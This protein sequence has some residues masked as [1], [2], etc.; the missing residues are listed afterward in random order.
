MSK[1]IL[2]NVNEDALENLTGLKVKTNGSSTNSYE[3]KHRDKLLNFIGKYHFAQESVLW[4]IKKGRLMTRFH[5]V[6][7]S[8]LGEVVM[9]DFNIPHNIKDGQNFAVYETDKL[10]KVLNILNNNIQLSLKSI[11]VEQETRYPNLKIKDEDTT[12]TFTLADIEA[13]PSVPNLVE[14]PDFQVEFEIDADFNSKFVKSY[15]ALTPLYKSFSV[16]TKD[17][18]VEIFIGYS[19]NINQHNVSIIPT[20]SKISKKIKPLSFLS[21]FFKN[22]ILAN[23]EFKTAKLKV[24][25]KGLAHI[26]F[27]NAEFQADYY[28]VAQD[29]Q[30]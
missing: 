17:D 7:K 3:P 21:S 1:R 30:G 11:K 27:E 25:E 10:K 12:V 26:Q 13:I 20:H 2:T 5:S 23:Q 28:H 29:A 24:S 15:N 22:C 16:H 18:R 19:Q 9:K 8:M 14:L 6:D 4:E